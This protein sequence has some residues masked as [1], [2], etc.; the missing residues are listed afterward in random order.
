MNTVLSFVADASVHHHVGAF[1][2]VH[3]VPFPQARVARLKD[4]YIAS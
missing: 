1:P 3:D 4:S 2:G